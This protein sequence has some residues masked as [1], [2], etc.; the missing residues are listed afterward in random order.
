MDSRI[1]KIVNDHPDLLLLKGTVSDVQ[2]E[3]IK[4]FFGLYNRTVVT[5]FTFNCVNSEE[6]FHGASNLGM[7]FDKGENLWIIGRQLVHESTEPHLVIRPKERQIGFWQY[8]TA[9]LI[10]ILIAFLFPF[11]FAMISIMILYPSFSLYFIVVLF[12]GILGCAYLYERK[13]PVMRTFD[14]EEWD[15]IMIYLNERFKLE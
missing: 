13:R 7:N 6:A 2:K 12:S 1:E 15:E 5:R 8:V 11:S 14:S 4:L 9:R 3:N 10:L